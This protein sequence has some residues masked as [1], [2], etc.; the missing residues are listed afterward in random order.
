MV[1]Y[2]RFEND[3]SLIRLSEPLEFN[4]FVQPHLPNELQVV[5]IPIIEQ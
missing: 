2:T 3:V 1:E 4:E 5:S